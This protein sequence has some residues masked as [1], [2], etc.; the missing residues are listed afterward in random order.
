VTIFF[1]SDIRYQGFWV[2]KGYLVMRAAELEAASLVWHKIVCRKP[3]GTITHGR[4]SYSHLLCFSRT[5]PA[6][7]NPGP[8]VLADAG[9]K[10]WPKAMGVDACRLA[11][12]YLLEE[13]DT[14]YVVDPF[15]GRGTLLAVANAMGLPGLGVDISARKCRAARSLML[16][17]KLELVP[18]A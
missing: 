11:C 15:C 13:T 2:D 7:R 18:R 16:N 10:P 6:G 5:L 4:A 3:P 12:R 17:E 1:Q 14:R 9:M 8:D